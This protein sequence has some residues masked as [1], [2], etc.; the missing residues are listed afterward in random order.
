MNPLNSVYISF[1]NGNN[2]LSGGNNGTDFSYI[3]STIG[4]SSGK[5]YWEAK[6]TDLAEIDQVGIALASA[7]FAS[8]GTSHGLQGTQYGG[9]GFQFSNG[10]KVGDGSQSAYMGGFSA[11]NI[12][13]IALDL[14]NNKITFGRDG[15][16]G[17]GSG[18][19]DQTYS[20]STP[21]YTNLTAGEF[22][23]AAHAMRGSGG[24]TGI[25]QYNFG[26]GYFG[27]TAVASAGTNASGNGIFEYDVPTGFTALSTK[28]LNL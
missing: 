11:N 12:M 17:N 1:L 19:A 18:G 14:D 3:G 7:N 13:M 5:Y 22:Y 15:Q 26:N 4:A 24:N 23:V 16:W 20:N 21:A 10:N 2:T 9:K 8:I 28:G 6:V 27:T 25:T